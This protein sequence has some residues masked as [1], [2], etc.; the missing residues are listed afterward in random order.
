MPTR[1]PTPSQ[2]ATLAVHELSHVSD[3]HREVDL[4]TEFDRISRMC[5]TMPIASG[6][7]KF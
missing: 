2:Q 3:P 5:G 1:N 7:L 4:Q 6:H